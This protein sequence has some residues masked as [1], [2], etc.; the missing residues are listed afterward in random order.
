MSDMVISP[1]AMAARMPRAAPPSPDPLAVIPSG[2]PPCDISNPET[3]RLHFPEFSDPG[4]Y[5]DFMVQLWLDAGGIMC[6]PR[7]WGR[8]RQIGVELF[9]AHFLALWRWANL[10]GGSGGGGTAP[11]INRG[12]LSSKSV[13]KVSVGYDF[14]NVS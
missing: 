10:G 1:R 3:F 5:T 4:V 2:I 12:L 6:V 13:S 7:V 11:G 9:C 14:A 8:M